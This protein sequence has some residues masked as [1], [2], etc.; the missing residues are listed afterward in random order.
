MDMKKERNAVLIKESNILKQERSLMA[1]LKA[2]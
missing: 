2:T 1:N